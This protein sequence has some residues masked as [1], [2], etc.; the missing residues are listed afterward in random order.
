MA[1][2]IFIGNDNKNLHEGKLENGK[3]YYIEGG[4]VPVEFKAKVVLPGMPPVQVMPMIGILVGGIDHCIIYDNLDAIINDWDIYSNDDEIPEGI[5][6]GVP[7]FKLPE[8]PAEAEQSDIAKT[9]LAGT[10]PEPVNNSGFNI[11]K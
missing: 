1:K 5:E 9:I 6:E 10:K 3:W 11:I 4:I 7:G 2:G 8:P